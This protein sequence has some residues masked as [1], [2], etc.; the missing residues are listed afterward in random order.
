[1]STI[2]LSFNLDNYPWIALFSIL[3]LNRENSWECEVKG[4][5][6]KATIWSPSGHGMVVVK[7]QI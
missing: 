7:S 1:M 4:N 5:I 6:L 2:F 3:I